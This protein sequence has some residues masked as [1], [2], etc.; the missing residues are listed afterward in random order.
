LKNHPSFNKRESYQLLTKEIPLLKLNQVP[1]KLQLSLLE[2]FNQLTQN[3]QI[4]KQL[5]WLQ[6][7]NWLSKLIKLF[8]ASVNSSKLQQDVVLVEPIQ[9]KTEKPLRMEEFKL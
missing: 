6:Q 9:E 5:F 3:L 7:E 8:I 2:S 4:V 1:E